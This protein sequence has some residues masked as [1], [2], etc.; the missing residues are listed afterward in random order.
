M[1][2]KNGVQ[3]DRGIEMRGVVD[4]G[5]V[6]V[7]ETITVVVDCTVPVVV[8]TAAPRAVGVWPAASG[9]AAA[10]VQFFGISSGDIPNVA[11]DTSSVGVAVDGNAGATCASVRAVD[12]AGNATFDVMAATSTFVAGDV[13]V[14]DDD[15][16]TTGSV[17]AVSA[18]A[19]IVVDVSAAAV[20]VN[21]A[22]VAV[23]S[24]A[25][26]TVAEVATETDA[27]VATSDV[28]T[29]LVVGVVSAA[30]V[31]AIS[32]DVVMAAD[33]EVAEA[34][35]A[36]A[37]CATG[38]ETT[39]AADVVADVVGAPAIAVDSDSVAAC[40]EVADAIVKNAAGCG[41]TDESLVPMNQAYDH[42]PSSSDE[43]SDSE[44]EDEE[45]CFDSD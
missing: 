20:G 40:V 41:V 45:E 3:V 12:A 23:V 37:A 15:I 25:D 5:V 24:M 17:A 22:H 28:A 1:M 36:N 29:G 2:R 27:A 42:I 44:E 7:A 13:V 39:A 26:G 6:G 34:G 11:A 14:A 16:A 9:A 32:A 4:A 18:H 43:R 38:A 30:L 35:V 33:A 31:V 21:V 19:F 8:A 10:L